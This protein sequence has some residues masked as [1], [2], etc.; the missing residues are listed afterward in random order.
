[1][2]ILKQNNSYLEI[3]INNGKLVNLILTHPQT[4]EQIKVIHDK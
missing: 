4:K 3:N 2:V 1:M